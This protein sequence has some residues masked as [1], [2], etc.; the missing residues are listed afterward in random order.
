MNFTDKRNA[1]ERLKWVEHAREGI[2]A[3]V[4]DVVG[5]V[6]KVAPTI[7]PLK[8]IL[9]I[10]LNRPLHKNT[11]PHLRTYLRC[12]A[13]QFGCELPIIRIDNQKVQAE[14]LTQT[15]VWNRSSLGRFKSGGRRFEKKP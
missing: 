7:D 13:Q 4:D 10:P 11:R 6:F 15:R 5:P 14:V 3:A 8:F 12:W 1:L 9:K 2:V